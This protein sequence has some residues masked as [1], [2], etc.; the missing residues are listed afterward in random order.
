MAEQGEKDNFLH[1]LPERGHGGTRSP[2]CC[3][4]PDPQ[5]VGKDHFREAE[6]PSPACP[7][8]TASALQITR[9]EIMKH[10]GKDKMNLKRQLQAVSWPQPYLESQKITLCLWSI[11]NPL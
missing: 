8:L 7:F 5:D 1:V 11:N 10:Y 9:E 6:L 4:R 3:P 2:G